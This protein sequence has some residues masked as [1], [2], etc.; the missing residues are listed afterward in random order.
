MIPMADQDVRLDL[1]DPP[2]NAA[3]EHIDPDRLAELADD[4]ASN[5]LLQRV[6]LIGPSPEGRYQVNWG[7]RR[8]RAARQLHWTTIAA[9]V[10]PWGTDPTVMRAAENHVR[11]QLNPR[12]EARQVAELLAAGKSRGEIRRI[13]RRSDAWIDARL[14]LLE[15]PADLQDAVAAGQLPLSVARQLLKIDH[16][17]YRR[18]LVG[19]AIRTGATERTA[20]VWAAAYGADRERFIRNDTTIQQMLEARDTF[21]I[22][23]RC[24]SCE[25][26]VNI[27]RTRLIRLCAGCSH[28]LE[29]AKQE[30]AAAR[31]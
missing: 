2:A 11:E 6:G 27:A 15:W 7:D 23:A 12:E 28:E 18:E 9:R 10:A 17:G 16:D 26:Q 20:I 24:D 30:A 1:I 13:L 21:E 14:G 22:L 19:E 4:L 8:T 29:A 31:Q 25:E 3:R 5:G